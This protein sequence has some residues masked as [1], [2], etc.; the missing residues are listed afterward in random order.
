MDGVYLDLG[1][2]TDSAFAQRLPLR[3]LIVVRR[4][5][6]IFESLETVCLWARRTPKEH[7]GVFNYQAQKVSPHETTNIISHP[8]CV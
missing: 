1:L 7:T 5:H 3:I 2:R 6:A 8:R 4:A